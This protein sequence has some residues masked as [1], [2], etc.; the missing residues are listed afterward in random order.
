MHSRL[1]IQVYL[2]G[3]F[4]RTCIARASVQNRGRARRSSRRRWP[5]RCSPSPGQGVVVALRVLDSS[6][7]RHK[8]RLVQ[9]TGRSAQPGGGSRSQHLLLAPERTQSIRLI[10]CPPVS[11]L[12][13]ATDHNI[14][15]LFRLNLACLD[16]PAPF[17]RRPDRWRPISLCPI[18]SSA[19]P[20]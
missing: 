7:L 16:R 17:V 11:V 14:A 9:R 4:A 18:A 3:L 8:I 15:P 2:S 19:S 1:S 10:V 12:D 13:L 6:L 5:R 20:A